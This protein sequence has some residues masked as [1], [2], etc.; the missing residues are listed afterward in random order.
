MPRLTQGRISLQGATLVAHSLCYCHVIRE[1]F[2]SRLKAGKLFLAIRVA[3]YVHFVSS[4]SGLP[5]SAVLILI[6]VELPYS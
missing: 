6:N 4:F 2:Q 1:C 5:G 3:P